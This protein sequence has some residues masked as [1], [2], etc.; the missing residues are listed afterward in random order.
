MGPERI[1]TP[2]RAGKCLRTVDVVEQSAVR[3]NSSDT[4]E[5]GV[6][7]RSVRPS[8][9]E[10]ESSHVVSDVTYGEIAH[11]EPV[12]EGEY[13]SFLYSVREAGTQVQHEARPFMIR[14]EIVNPHTGELVRVKGLVDDG[15]MVSVMDA[16][17]WEKVR[18][19]LPLA[20]KS[21]RT[22]RMANG[23]T[24]KSEGQWKGPFKFEG[25]QADSA[26]EIFPS[27]GAWS[28]LVGKPMLEALEAVHD[29][30]RDVITVRN[31]T[32]QAEIQN[33]YHQRAL[34]DDPTVDDK[35]YMVLT[36]DGSG[37]G[38]KKYP[39]RE[40]EDMQQP[41]KTQHTGAEKRT[42]RR[43]PVEI[44]EEEDEQIGA[45]TSRPLPAE[46]KFVLLDD[47][48]NPDAESANETSTL[49]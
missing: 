37:G 11:I 30:G 5:V 23:A 45:S 34:G 1:R 17:L 38:E 22:L 27:G 43:R 33:C 35:M 4:I 47:D 26:F 9:D 48:D 44:E 14:F 6:P 40:V 10:H 29:Y 19:R 12:E 7:A 18:H 13:T 2:A 8:G 3:E 24:S 49:R 15:A 46:S 25:V 31:G 36:G 21:I 32:C 28:F 41:D 39:E 20:K 16:A 42:P